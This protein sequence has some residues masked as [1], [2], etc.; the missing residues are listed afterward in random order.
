MNSKTLIH[1]PIIQKYRRITG[2]KMTVIT[3]KMFPAKNGD[4]FLVSL[5][6]EEKKHI[7]IDCGYAETYKNFLKDELKTIA[8]N[9]EMIDLMVISHVDQDH[10]LGAIS[11][12]ED[13]NKNPFIKIKEIWYNGY[14]HLQFDKE[15]VNNITTKEKEMLKGQIALG[16]SFVNR[17]KQKNNIQEI[18]ARQGFTL[19][20][21]IT[22]GQY[23]WNESFD[24]SAVSIDNKNI[25]RK[26]G[27]AIYLISPNTEKLSKLSDKWLKELRRMKRGFSLSDEEIFDEAYECYMIQQEEKK[28]EEKLISST[29]KYKVD[30]CIED[31]ISKPMEEEIDNAPIN[32]SS[33]S[34]IIEYN[35]KNLLFLA[36]AH[37][38][39]ILDSLLKLGDNY[40][41]LIKVSHHGSA[42]NTTNELAKISNSS[43]FLISTNG[44]G[45][46]SHP[47][48]ESLA[49]IIYHQ[50]NP[51]TLVFNYK[52]NTAKKVD[53]IAWKRK[54][55][56]KVHISDG[57]TPTIIKL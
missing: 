51:K 22:D 6:A 37:P 25:I 54:Y 56:Y 47:D 11:F 8:N 40:F 28:I 23:S 46:Y 1:N 10:I 41:D 57:S 44:R 17:M 39:I 29:T 7:L 48:F 38:D 13:N 36:D 35:G 49:K 5:G 27:Y 24:G 31:V 55:N 21:L 12:L 3:V 42:K 26:K 43:L 52:T 14:K 34:I 33:I 53:N 9:N 30:K 18:S 16:S 20:S 45:N 50:K 4:C 2:I 32:G 19:A 15:K